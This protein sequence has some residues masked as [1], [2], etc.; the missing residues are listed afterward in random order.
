MLGECP[1]SV[2]RHTY[3][4]TMSVPSDTSY[5]DVVSD[6]SPVGV[7]APAKR[8]RDVNVIKQSNFFMQFVG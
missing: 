6:L 2:P 7:C 3:R 4:L 1:K 5:G 8:L